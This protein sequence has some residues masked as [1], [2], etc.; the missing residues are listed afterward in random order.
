MKKPNIFVWFM[1][2]MGKRLPVYLLAVFVSTVG[3]AGSMIANAWLVKNVMTAAQTKETEGLL[4]TVVI[5]FAVIVLSMFVW[6]F[7]IVRY[8]IEAKR[9]IARV[10]KRVFE[11]VLR[12][13]VSYYENKHSGDF[14]SKLVYDMEKAGDIYGSRFRRLADAVLSTIIYAIPMFVLNWQLTLCLVSLS[15]FSLVVNGLF[16]KPMKTYGGK[17]SS[18]NTG[19]TQKLTNILSGMETIKIFPAGHKALE[20]Y[21]IA[22]EECYKVQKKTN[23]ISAGLESINSMC[24]LLSSLAF[25]AVG[26]LFVSNNLANM[27]ELT[28]IYTIYG[29]FRRVVLEVG[30]YIPQMMS[31]V[32]NAERIYDFLALEEESKGYVEETTTDNRLAFSDNILSVKDVSYGYTEER[33]VLKDFS[34]E[35]KKVLVLFSFA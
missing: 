26:V 9:G 5:N 17:L 10:E 23:Y 28:A 3:F 31:C 1:G 32:A 16:M 20:E 30:K 7:G 35:V 33:E 29:S 24:D 19:L 11:K 25:L 15:A 34:L 12:L 8:N 2:L 14:M 13:P 6:R 22:N 27:G 4:L 18:K 21:D